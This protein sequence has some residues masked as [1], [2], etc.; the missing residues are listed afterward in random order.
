MALNI[1]MVAPQPFFR[2]RGTP[3]SV[4]HRIRALTA[5]GHRV[6]LVTYPFGEDIEMDRLVI[7]RAARPP[8]VSDVA[9]GPSFTKLALDFPLYIRA[10]RLLKEGDFDLI[11]SHEEAAFFCVNLARRHGKPHIYDMHSSLPQQLANFARFNLKPVESLFRRQEERVLDSCDGVIT[12][13]EDLA[14]IVEARC[15]DTPHSMI[16]NTGDDLKVFSAAERDVRRELD[17]ADAKIVLYTGTF[18]PYQG[19]DLLREAFKIVVTE[20]PEAYLLL[21]GGRNEQVEAYRQDLERDCLG[22]RASLVGTVH[23]SEIPSYLSAADLIVSPRS[24]GTNTPL[25]IYGYMRSG[26]PIVATDRLTH[27]QTLSTE[28]A[29]LVE[30]TPNGL[31]RGISRVLSDSGRAESIARAAAVY[32]D[33]EYSDAAYVDKVNDLYS[34]VLSKASFVSPEQRTASV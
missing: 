17:L 32:V 21:V 13:C 7:T 9:I 4:L 15:A 5:H 11:H 24:S 14:R 22:D 1:L 20:T 3:F 30:P 26:K 34:K 12:I 29:E 10:S 18:E 25:K 8:F 27:T 23:P 33:R 28:T 19:L 6:T 31:A 2:A 16:E